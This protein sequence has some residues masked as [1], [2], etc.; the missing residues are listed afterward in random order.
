MRNV[1][2]QLKGKKVSPWV[3]LLRRITRWSSQFTRWV[4][5]AIIHS[6][7]W[8]AALAKLA[9]LMRAYMR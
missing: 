4:Q 9:P 1:V 7:E 6:W 8:Q 3:G 2:A 5:D